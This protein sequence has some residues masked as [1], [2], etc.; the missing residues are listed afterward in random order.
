MDGTDLQLLEIEEEEDRRAAQRSFLRFYMRMTGFQPPMHVRVACK[1]AQAIEE[2]K[3]DR[4]MIFMPPRHAKTTL[5]SHLLPAWVIGR[6]PGTAVMGVAHTDRYGKK[7]GGKVRGYMRHPAWPWPEVT[8]S[9]DTQAKEAF[10]TPQG[11]E[12][13]AFGM[14]GGNQHGNPAEWLFMDDI[15]KGRKIAMS[16]HMRAEAWETYRT[17]LLSRLQGRAKQLMIFTRWNE[18]DPAGRIL[19]ENFDGRS[20]WYRDRETGEKWYVLS[21]P[22]VAEHDNDPTKRKIGDWLWPEAFGEKKLGA[23]QKRGGW[24]WSALYQ[25]RPSPQEGL[26]FTADMIQRYE[27]GRLN[28]MAL[29]IYISSDYA[30]TEEAG[31]PDPDYTVHMVLGVDSDHNIFLLDMWRGRSTS[32]VWVNQWIRL[33]KKHKPLRAIEEGGQI[34]R[35]VGPFLKLIMK[36]EKVFVNRVQ[37][38]STT[39]SGNK[40]QR[41][42][43]LLGMAS[44]GKLFL[45]RRDQIPKYLLTHLDAFEKELLQFPAGRHDDTVDA[46]T[47]FGRFIDR[48]LEGKDEDRRTAPHEETLEDLFEHHDDEIR[49]Q[50]EDNW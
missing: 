21:L 25:Q 33:V 12:Y 17:D 47:L 3:V 32:D 11:G 42:H 34:I 19:P 27:P 36:R 37:I 41:A 4:A 45:P 24:V 5:F 49:R 10:A 6:N 7:I 8:L 43:A 13:N 2:D 44:M 38:N 31:A 9:G 28:K 18:D 22:A 16:P 39:Q 35:G 23:M 26:M 15:I 30:V 40:E 48:I 14:F 20:G 50:S 46:A 1:L 29:N